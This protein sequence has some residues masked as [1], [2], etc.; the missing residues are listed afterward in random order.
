MYQGN[1]YPTNTY[2]LFSEK[3]ER[4]IYFPYSKVECAR[5]KGTTSEIFIDQKTIDDHIVAQAEATYEFVLR[6]INKGALVRGVY[7]SSR[8]EYPIIAI[9]E[10]IR[11]K[12]IVPILKKLGIIDQWGNGLKQ[13]VD[14]LNDYPEI[15]FR[16]F[17][18]GLQF[19]VQFIKKDSMLQP[20]LITQQELQQETLFSLI[21]KRYHYS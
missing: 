8:W 11:N 4:L 7:T 20:D 21:L 6:H 17:E 18:I 2:V 9:R 16:W 12:T 14:E 13:I 15:E 1:W 5:F 19:Q 3:Q 10:T